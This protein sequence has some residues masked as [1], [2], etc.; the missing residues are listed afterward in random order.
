[1]KFFIA[2]ILGVLTLSSTALAQY[3]QSTAK[4]KSHF[5]KVEKVFVFSP[6]NKYWAAYINGKKIRDGVANGGK[7]GYRTPTGVFYVMSKKGVHY[8][9]SRYPINA[10]GTRGGAFMPYAMHFTKNGHAIHGSPEISNQNSSHGCIRVK[11]AAAKWL[12]ESFI[13]HGTKVVVYPY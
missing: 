13:T 7:P 12:S 5:L 2:A 1:M 8:V 3:D 6:H 9:S 4:K 11:T 10:N